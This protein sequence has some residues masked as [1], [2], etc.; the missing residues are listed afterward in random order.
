M[1]RLLAL[2]LK[3][4]YDLSWPPKRDCLYVSVGYKRAKM[5][6]RKFYYK[7]NNGQIL[8]LKLKVIIFKQNYVAKQDLFLNTDCYQTNFFSL[9][10]FCT[11][12][13]RKS[14]KTQKI[15]L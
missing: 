5:S 9:V 4:E 13:S 1:G 8:V 7:N 14:T 11:I 10:I 6:L 2:Y 3:N 15:K 12:L